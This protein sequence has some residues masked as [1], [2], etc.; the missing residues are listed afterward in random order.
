MARSEFLE[1]DINRIT[2]SIDPAP[3]GI[4]L[5]GAKLISC[6]RLTVLR[7]VLSQLQRTGGAVRYKGSGGLHHAKCY[8][9]IL[10]E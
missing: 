5:G 10:R 8:V 9:L 2:R 4:T 7:N 3:L 1:T 6:I